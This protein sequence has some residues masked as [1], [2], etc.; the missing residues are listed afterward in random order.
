L[1][2]DAYDD[3]WNTAL[4]AV[5]T[6]AADRNPLGDILLDLLPALLLP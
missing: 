1:Y 4:A 2:L 3:G 5:E 6:E